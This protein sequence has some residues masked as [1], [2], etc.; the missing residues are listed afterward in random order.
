MPRSASIKQDAKITHS[1]TIAI[2]ML[3]NSG[4]NKTSQY[5]LFLS[6][7]KTAV[8]G[9]A[10]YS[11]RADRLKALETLFRHSPATYSQDDS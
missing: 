6:N 4:H 3:K 8:L 7:K 11:S 9:D 5:S 1:S 2:R 10:L